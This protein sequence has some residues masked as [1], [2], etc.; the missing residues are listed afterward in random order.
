MKGAA[1]RVADARA[2][3]RFSALGRETIVART[4]E[5]PDWTTELRAHP[6]YG[7]II[8]DL[9]A[10]SLDEE[11]NIPECSRDYKVVG[12]SMDHEYLVLGRTTLFAEWS[13]SEGRGVF[14]EAHAG[15]LAGHCGPE[16]C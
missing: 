5:E 8:T 2:E 10:G 14:D 6:V 7:R 4:S 9:E 1:N 15:L 16:N 11:V 13:P 12:F 3:E